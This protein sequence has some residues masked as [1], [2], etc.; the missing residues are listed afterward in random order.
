MDGDSAMNMD[1][2]RLQAAVE[3]LKGRVVALEKT[4]T[5]GSASSRRAWVLEKKV[6]AMREQANQIKAR[7]GLHSDRSDWEVNKE[8]HKDQVRKLAELKAKI[9]QAKNEMGELE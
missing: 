3:D 4:A 7:Y 8:R 9:A 6:E 5:K 2:K 1:V